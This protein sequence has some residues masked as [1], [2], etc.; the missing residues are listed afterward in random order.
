[1]AFTL[2]TE[3]QVGAGKK[4]GL[5]RELSRYTTTRGDVVVYQTHALYSEFDH[6]ASRTRGG[7]LARR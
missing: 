1:M 2:R 5:A 7:I 4:G 3:W 6:F